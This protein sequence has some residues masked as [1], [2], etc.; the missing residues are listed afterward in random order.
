MIVP[1][2]QK[3]VSVVIV[4]DCFPCALGLKVHG[5][6]IVVDYEVQSNWW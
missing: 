2:R 4:N 6:D 5:L 1:L 3:Q